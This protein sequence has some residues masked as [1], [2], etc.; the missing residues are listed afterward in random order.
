MNITSNKKPT[1]EF[2]K[3]LRDARV[4]MGLTQK[5]VSKLTGLMACT[6]S[7]LETGDRSPNERHIAVIAKALNLDADTLSGAVEQKPVQRQE[8][9]YD[10]VKRTV[11]GKPEAIR[12]PKDLQRLSPEKFTRALSKILSGHLQYQRTGL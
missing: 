6:L 5:E 8:P 2:G 4:D 12:T 9:R 10:H 3:L 1:T 11:L 7:M